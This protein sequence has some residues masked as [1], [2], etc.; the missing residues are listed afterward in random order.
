RGRLADFARDI[1]ACD[2]VV[3]GDTLTMHLALALGVPAV[4]L[5]LCTSPAEIHGYGRLSKVVSPL[6]AK[7]FYARGRSPAPGAA[8][9]AADVARKVRE[10]LLYNQARI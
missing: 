10:A 5:F 1:A 7:H 3:C 9:A 4:A 6:W 8:V 2:L